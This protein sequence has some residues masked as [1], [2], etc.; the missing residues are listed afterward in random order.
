MITVEGQDLRV[1]DRVEWGH[2]A[3]GAELKQI[4]RGYV[5]Q[6]L[7]DTEVEV[8]EEIAYTYSTTLH[9]LPIEVLRSRYR[10]IRIPSAVWWPEYAGQRP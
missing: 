9:V 10:P 1:G 3:W 4:K 2:P 6:F 5:V 7:G 8:V